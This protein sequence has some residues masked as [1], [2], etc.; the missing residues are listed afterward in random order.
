MAL[1]AGVSSLSGHLHAG[2]DQSVIEMMRAMKKKLKKTDREKDVRNYILS[3]LDKKSGDRTGTLHGFGHAVYTISD[4]RSIILKN[5]ADEYSRQK[6][7]SEDFHLFAMVEEIGSEILSEKYN[8]PICT[9]IDFY[10][11]LLYNLMGIPDDLFTPIFAMARMAGW[12]SHRIEQRQEGK[13]IRPAYIMPDN[14]LK[15]YPPNRR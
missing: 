10:T 6:G 7:R 13:I 2:S 1:G 8:S 11:A 3:V 5:Y 14:Y 4:P 15:E 9:N 12:S